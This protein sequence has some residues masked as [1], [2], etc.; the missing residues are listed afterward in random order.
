MLYPVFQRFFPRQTYYYLACGGSNTLFG[1]FLY[2]VFYHYVFGKENWDL[3]FY[4][5]K[6]HIAAFILSFA[7]TFPIGFYLS[8]YVVWNASN[9]KGRVQLFRHFVFVVLSVFMNYGLLKLFVEFLHWWAMPSQILTTVIIVV[10]SYLT[11]RFVTF[12]Q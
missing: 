11:Q 5:I 4:A 2:Y 9:T 12:R 6:P 10:F 3:G 8:K 1:L 7:S